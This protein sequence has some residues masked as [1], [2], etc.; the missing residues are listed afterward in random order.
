[1][2]LEKKYKLYT[3]FIPPRFKPVL[4]TF[5]RSEKIDRYNKNHI[6]AEEWRRKKFVQYSPSRLTYEHLYNTKALYI[7]PE[8]YVKF[9]YLHPQDQEKYAPSVDVNLKKGE[10]AVDED[11]FFI[12]KRVT[13]SDELFDEEMKL[14]WRDEWDFIM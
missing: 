5:T 3:G 7:S 1:M 6:A 13:D 8:D 2:S 11:N 12:K 4:P 10:C 9:S 14:I